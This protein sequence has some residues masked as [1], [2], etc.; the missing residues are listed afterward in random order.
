MNRPFTVISKRATPARVATAPPSARR[1]SAK[2]DCAVAGAEG[3]PRRRRPARSRLPPVSNPS[4]R[5]R[6]AARTAA[7]RQAVSGKD[8]PAAGVMA[9]DSAAMGPAGVVNGRPCR[10]RGVGVHVGTRRRRS[11]SSRRASRTSP[12]RPTP[13]RPVG[14]RMLHG[15]AVAAARRPATAV[16]AVSAPNPDRA[17]IAGGV[18]DRGRRV[19][20][21]GAVMVA[22]PAPVARRRT[23]AGRGGTPSR[24]SRCRRRRGD[25]AASCGSSRSAVWARSART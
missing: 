10:R 21:N 18:A 3:D 20:E 22:A 16:L 25:R 5:P 9:G 12:R 24:V 6:R 2:D 4:P 23:A 14:V 17:A 7:G 8:R 19:A 11:A 1:P 15:D 13:G